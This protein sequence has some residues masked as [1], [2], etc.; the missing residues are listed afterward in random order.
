MCSCIG[1]STRRNHLGEQRL[2]SSLLLR[3]QHLLHATETSVCWKKGLTFLRF[4]VPIFINEVTQT[5][6]ERGSAVPMSPPCWVGGGHVLLEQPPVLDT[7]EVSRD[8]QEPSLKPVGPAHLRLLYSWSSTGNCL[9]PP[10]PPERSP[11]CLHPLPATAMGS[12]DPRIYSPPGQ[13]LM[14]DLFCTGHITW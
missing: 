10:Q 1:L 13:S 9:P 3:S 2:S 4:D 14:S 5:N 11:L 12:H 7:G 6:L 8:Q